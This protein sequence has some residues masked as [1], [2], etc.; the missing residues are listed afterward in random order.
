MIARVAGALVLLAVAVAAALVTRA[1]PS[2]YRT[3]GRVLPPDTAQILQRCE[4]LDSAA[5][6]NV[7]VRDS[8]TG[9]PLPNVWLADDEQF[10]VTDAKGWACLRSLTRLPESLVLTREGYQEAVLMLSG[11]AERS[12]RRE[13]RMHR[14]DAPCCDLRGEWR[15]RLDL[16]SPSGQHPNP[17]G[18][19]TSGTLRLETA[20]QTSM[21][22]P[23]VDEIVRPVIG[24]FD[25]DLAPFFGGPYAKDVSTTVFGGGPDLLREVSATV[26]HTDSVY[27]GF[28]PRMSHG[29]LS[30]SGRI[31]NDT[32]RGEWIQNAYCCGAT[33]RFEM[34]R[35]AAYDSSGDSA[36]RAAAAPS[37][38]V[39][40]RSG[41]SAEFAEGGALPEGQWRPALSVGPKGQIWFAVGGLYRASQFG[42]AWTRVLGG[43]TGPI[44]DDELRIGISLAHPTDSVTLLGLQSRWPLE[45]SPVL[46]RSVDGGASWTAVTLGGTEEVLAMAGLGRSVWAM[47]MLGRG[48]PDRLL[49]SEDAGATWRATD[50]P[51]RLQ[52]AAVLHRVDART[53]FVGSSD[54]GGAHPF[55]RT[56]DGGET[57]T[58]VRGPSAQ[59][60]QKS[61]SSRGDISEIASVGSYLLVR[62]DEAV[63][64]ADRAAL[65][66]RAMPDVERIA[67]E[68]GDQRLLVLRPDGRVSLLDSTLQTLWTTAEAA[69]ATDD[70]IEH[71]LW[72]GGVGYISPKS[73]LL[74]EVRNGTVRELRALKPNHSGPK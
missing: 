70:G 61:R 19:H 2:P 15:I 22:E 43:S 65:K 68:A 40:R 51:T 13:V 25:V 37:F 46:Y 24:R 30:L 6:V 54:Y 45:R 44:A 7:V 72:R 35:T 38:G 49:R 57:W 53:A 11:V 47:V 28:I 73:G 56:E 67:S 42:S 36:R 48:A 58:V 4:P 74:V 14:V 55:W 62:E 26:P 1:W 31:R 10:V 27:L 66:W 52:D 5:A 69:V 39:R 23:I 18:R 71:I 60:L 41:F 17:A 8:R 9:R 34:V 63:F 50:L 59:G 21:G 12:V 3:A 20:F 32:I 64:A 29:G 16:D 33:G